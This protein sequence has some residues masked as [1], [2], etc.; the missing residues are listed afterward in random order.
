MLRID[1]MNSIFIDFGT[2]SVKAVMNCDP[3]TQIYL[4]NP[5]KPYGKDIIT[6]LDNFCFGEQRQHIFKAG[7]DAI[8]NVIDHFGDPDCPVHVVGN[9]GIISIFSDKKVEKLI[10]APHRNPVDQDF[11]V[12]AG[13]FS[14]HRLKNEIL[15]HSPL[16]GFV[17]SDA[18]CN[19]LWL[20]GQKSPS[21]LIDIGT[22]IEVILFSEGRFLYSS[23]AGGPAFEDDHIR[24]AEDWKQEDSDFMIHSTGF[25]S[26]LDDCPA[27]VCAADIFPILVHLLEQ[28][29]ITPSGR[30]S[31]SHL[32]CKVN[33][34][35]GNIGISQ[36]DIRN[37]QYAKSALAAAI[38][39]LA[40]QSGQD[41]DGIP[42]YLTG[43]FGTALRIPDAVKTGFLPD[44]TVIHLVPDSIF[45]GMTHLTDI[46]MVEN[47]RNSSRYVSVINNIL[48]NGLFL[49]YFELK[50]YAI[51]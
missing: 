40:R 45:K 38:L 34:S 1:S 47:I 5:Q 42:V 14:N 31:E 49:E 18:L 32:A 16:E 23:V 27:K 12:C 9:T 48:F 20:S 37:F 21:L 11:T 43:S 19:L 30:F 24:C 22:N 13:E 10:Q 7:M 6:R 29:V 46:S 8:V 39:T 41:L 28:G 26:V 3:E 50:S 36:K 35:R 25:C 33:S 44:N 4:P 17:G 51:S 15:F 2:S